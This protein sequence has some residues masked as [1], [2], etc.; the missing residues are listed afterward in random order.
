MSFQIRAEQSGTFC[1]TDL[2]ILY[3]TYDSKRVLRFSQ[4]GMQCDRRR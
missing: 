4:S 2:R 1:D 3:M